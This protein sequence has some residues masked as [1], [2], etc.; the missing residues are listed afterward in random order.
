MSKIHFDG[1]L[2][3]TTDVIIVGAGIVGAA[4]AYELA[5]HGLHVTVI[6]AGIASATHAGMGHLVMMDDLAA[7]LALS[8][9]SVKLWHALAKKLSPDC[10]FRATPTLWLA[11]SEAEMHIAAEKYQRLSQAG[12]QCQLLNQQQLYQL[13]PQLKAG[14]FGG[15][16]VFDDGIVYA[17]S[18]AEWFLQQYPEK[19]TRIHAHVQH[20]HDGAVSMTDGTIQYAPNI[21]LA[22]GIQATDFFPEFPIQAKKGHLAITDRY[23]DVQINHTLVALAYAAGTQATSGTAVA[24]NIQPRPTGQLFIGSSRQFNTTDPTLEPQIMRKVLQQAVDYLPLL[25][26]LNILRTWTGFRAATPDGVPIIGQHPHHPSVYLA[27]G[28]EGLGVTTATGTAKLI[29]A[30]I[31]QLLCDIDP[32]AFSAARFLGEKN[33]Q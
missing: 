17:P 29:C 18:A 7:E 16:K 5:Q 22:N 14:L 11:C 1:V 25:G 21:V 30:M 31:C 24:C 15:L 20:I 13:E 10:A 33:D 23:P 4:C 26:D 19:I 3:M 27:I 6:D 28:H 8:V 12:V 2:P 9:W 32:T